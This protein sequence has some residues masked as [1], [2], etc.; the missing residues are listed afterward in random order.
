MLT[1]TKAT[2]QAASR[3]RQVMAGA[4][5][6]VD[7]RQSWDIATNTNLM[8]TYV[9]YPPRHPA[10]VDARAALMRMTGVRKVEISATTGYMTI[11]REA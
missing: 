3:V 8:I 11:V 6:T 7:T 4:L 5:V 10:A 9:T 1:K 2:S